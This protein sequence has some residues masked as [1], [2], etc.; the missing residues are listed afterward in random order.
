MAAGETR[1]GPHPEGEA[2]PLQAL[3]DGLA[4]ALVTA[5]DDLSGEQAVAV[6]DAH[7]QGL[8]RQA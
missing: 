1:P 3:I 2:T 5:P 7:L 8:R 6:L 4:V